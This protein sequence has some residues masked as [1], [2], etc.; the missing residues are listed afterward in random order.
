MPINWLRLM[1][2]Q[3]LPIYNVEALHVNRVNLVKSRRFSDDA[4][5]GKMAKFIQ[6]QKGQK[7]SM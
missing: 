3:C 5:I 2:V 6:A 1:L 4:L 7:K